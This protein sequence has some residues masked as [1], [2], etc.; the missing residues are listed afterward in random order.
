VIGACCVGT[1]KNVGIHRLS[2]AIGALSFAVE[3]PGFRGRLPY[4][5][6]AIWTHR[7]YSHNTF[8]VSVCLL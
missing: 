8:F 1:H 4:L 3:Y 5:T 6:I 2:W 7:Q